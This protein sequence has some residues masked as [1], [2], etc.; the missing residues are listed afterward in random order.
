MKSQEQRLLPFSKMWKYGIVVKRDNAYVVKSNWN[1]SKQIFEDEIVFDISTTVLP[2]IQ[3]VVSYCGTLCDAICKKLRK[4]PDYLA[5]V[6]EKRI[7]EE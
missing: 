5:W 1:E 6:E 3:A 4:R 7:Q 2:E